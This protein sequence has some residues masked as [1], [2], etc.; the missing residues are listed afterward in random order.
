VKVLGA[1]LI[2]SELS[3]RIHRIVV[4]AGKDELSIIARLLLINPLL[5]CP[6]DDQ[7]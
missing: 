5:F 4:H 7:T 2:N 6:V 3:R 1:V